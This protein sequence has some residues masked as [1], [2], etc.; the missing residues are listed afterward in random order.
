M[1]NDFARLYTK[2]G[3]NLPQIPLNEYPRPA[4]VRDSFFCLNGKWQFENTKSDKIPKAFTKEI[5][6]PFCPESLLS[7][8]E[9]VFDEK[10]FLYYKREFTLPKDF[11]KDRVF[12]NFGAVAQCCEVYLNGKKIGEH[13]G[14][15]HPFSFEITQ[16]LKQSNTLILKVWDRL[17]EHIFPYGKQKRKR[18]GMWYTP[19]SGIWQTVFI[20]STPKSYVRSLDI[21]ANEA[22]AT[23]KIDGIEEGE[24]TVFTPE[25]EI[26]EKIISSQVTVAPK[27][28]QLWCPE[29]PYLYRFIIKSGEDEVRSYFALRT[30]EIKKIKGKA[31]LC[32]N[33][34]PYFFHGLLDQGY[35]SDGLLT[36]ASL[37]CYENDIL[38][39]KSLGFNMLRKHIKIEP[40]QFYYDCDR[41]GMVV[42]QDMVN[43]G[44]YSFLRDTA[45]PTF[46]FKSIN[47]KNMHKNKRSREQFEKEM[48]ETVR[49]LKNHPSVCYFTIFN[50]GWGQ[51]CADK[52]YEKLK[53]LDPT[54]F[55][56]STSGWFWQSKTD[57]KSEHIYFKPYHFKEDEKPT[58]LSEF[59]GY[60]YR[61]E[62]HVFNLKKAYGYRFFKDQSEFEKELLELYKREVIP[63][64]K[65]GLSA[66][67]Y[68]QLSDVEDETNGLLSY[69]RKVLKVDAEK[70][71][72]MAEELFSAATE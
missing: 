37:K 15:Y 30:L 12:L 6:V 64:A 5:T 69:D 72:K 45:L 53:A 11:V 59:G 1:K 33:N 44:S 50:E 32:L 39:A 61:P 9:A 27:N 41:L 60:S 22:S 3:E 42:F 66:A 38:K 56:D 71:T 40:Q 23:I 17:S 58:V 20:E 16:W 52:M 31:R 29:N 54:R 10:D 49:L 18:G 65:K 19:T 47:D 28:P 26:K 43:N 13:S 4:L 24:I 70:M 68:T 35:F 7:G 63:A 62:G 67:V 36:P 14:G 57:V 46:G 55:I 34:K 2:E 21:L 48:Y 25:G 51:F 8:I